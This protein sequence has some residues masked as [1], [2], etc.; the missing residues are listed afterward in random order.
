MEPAP[1]TTTTSSTSSSSSSSSS[2]LST[3]TTTNLSTTSSGV[4]GGC[5]SSG[6]GSSSN[7]SSSRS[8][9]GI[10]SRREG[11]AE[12]GLKLVFRLQDS[13]RDDVVERAL[14]KRGWSRFELFEADGVTPVPLGTNQDLAPEGVGVNSPTIEYNL[15]FK[16]GRFVK[17]EFEKATVPSAPN[18]LRINHFQ[19]S[20]LITH[21]G[22]L[23]RLMKKLLALHGSIFDF[24]PEGYIL[25]SEYT[26]FIK[27]YSKCVLYQQSC[28]TPLVSCDCANVNVLILHTF[29]CH[30]ICSFVFV[31][32]ASTHDFA[33]G[34][35]LKKPVGS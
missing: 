15:H 14:L 8:S 18:R 29:V 28:L 1:S 16:R 4:G 23:L 21:K 20:N 30:A 6:S 33:L 9:S 24:A 5:S 31:F 3:T 35:N 22:K 17:T 11:V 7:S 2:S 32:L 19:K 25:P 34:T 10:E 13:V 26:K 12:H 27:A